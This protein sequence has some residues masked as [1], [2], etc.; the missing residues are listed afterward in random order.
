[1]AQFGASRLMWGSDFPVVSSRE[2]YGFAR[3]WVADVLSDTLDA[4]D[5][6]LV[7]GGTAKRL[8]FEPS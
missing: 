1:M 2:G 5:L 3:K 8:F 4:A 7:F 6:E